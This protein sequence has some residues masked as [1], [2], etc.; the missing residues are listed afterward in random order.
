MDQSYF[1]AFKTQRREYIFEG[2]N[3]H[4][5][6]LNIN[7]QIY[8]TTHFTR[9]LRTVY[10]L[11]WE[12][13]RCSLCWRKGCYVFRKKPLCQNDCLS[14]YQGPSE[15][16][17]N[18]RFGQNAKITPSEVDFRAEH[19]CGGY[20]HLHCFISEIFWIFYGT[21][22]RHF[23]L[24]RNSPGRPGRKRFLPGLP[25]NFK[26]PGKSSHSRQARQENVSA[27]SAWRVSS[28]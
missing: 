26:F 8:Q 16:V 12:L 19:P 6:R 10:A 7:L 15:T 21:F 17:K 24:A 23:L 22:S 18:S 1:F 25:E 13:L 4:A 11:I 28:Q 27:W 14:I 2:K 3:R 5:V 20:F 9:G